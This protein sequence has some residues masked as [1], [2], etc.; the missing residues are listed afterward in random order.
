MPSTSPLSAMWRGSQQLS[1]GD[2]HISPY[3]RPSLRLAEHA[4]FTFTQGTGKPTEF[5]SATGSKLTI[6]KLRITP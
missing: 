6:E 2:A 5:Q 4:A 1:P 3:F